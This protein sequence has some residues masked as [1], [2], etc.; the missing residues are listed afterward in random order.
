MIFNKSSALGP[1]PDDVDNVSQELLPAT[2]SN[3][4]GNEDDTNSVPQELLAIVANKQT[5][6][7]GGEPL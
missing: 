3:K 5:D 6:D 2:T 7:G 4:Q 1:E